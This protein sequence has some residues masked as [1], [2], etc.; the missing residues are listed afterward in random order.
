VGILMTIGGIAWVITERSPVNE[1][2]G[3]ARHTTMGMICAIG[4]GACQ[5]TGGLFSKMAM[6]R[7]TPMEL[8][9]FGATAWRM[10][11]GFVCV[12]PI[13]IWHLRRTKVRRAH[14]DHGTHRKRIGE[15]VRATAVGSVCGPVIGV[16]LS[17]TAYAGAPLG[18]AQTLC[19]LSPVLV[20]P[21]LVWTKR[22]RVTVRAAMG[23]G[24]AVL[25]CAVLFLSV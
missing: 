25:G 6:A 2:K 18:I 10:G 13:V 11:F 17:L 12:L 9:P 14:E 22:D 16:W 4:A 21:I 8:D 23:A 20:L 5:S 15:G 19:S 7:G 3:R 24:V 1:P